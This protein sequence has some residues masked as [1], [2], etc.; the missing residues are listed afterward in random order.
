MK[1][2]ER[3]RLIEEIGAADGRRGVAKWVRGWRRLRWLQRAVDTMPELLHVVFDPIRYEE[4]D[5]HAVGA[6]VGIDVKEVEH[7][8]SCA[9]RY[10]H[11][12]GRGE[13]SVAEAQ[14]AVPR[15]EAELAV[16]R[17]RWD[18]MWVELLRR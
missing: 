10:L 12:V 7:R 18:A 8:F 16:D 3:V 6:R 1:M 4:L 5:Y 14:A 2:I 13:M 15:T 17:V 11:L 9:L